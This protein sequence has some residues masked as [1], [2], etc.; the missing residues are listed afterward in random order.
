[1]CMLVVIQLVTHKLY[2]NKH[3]HCTVSCVIHVGLAS[4]IVKVL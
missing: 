2:H 1:M 3:A 4:G